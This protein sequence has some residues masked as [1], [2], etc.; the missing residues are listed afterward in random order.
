MSEIPQI[1]WASLCDGENPWQGKEG[2]VV[3][4]QEERVT[5]ALGKRKSGV[6]SL[7][8]SHP[9]KVRRVLDASVTLVPWPCCFDT[10]GPPWL[11]G[12]R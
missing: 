8:P 7:D 2:R 11:I 6:M 10:Q 12:S 9:R 3:C 1:Q 4:A 5:S